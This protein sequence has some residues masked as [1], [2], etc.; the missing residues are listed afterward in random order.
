MREMMRGLAGKAH[1]GAMQNV[2]TDAGD[3]IIGGADGSPVRVGK[4]SDDHIMKMV[5]GVP[6]WTTSTHASSHAAGQ[7]D[8]ISPSDIGAMVNPMTAEGDILVGG[9]SGAPSKLA[10]GNNGQVVS[11]V[12][13]VPA[14]ATIS[15]T[16]IGG[17][18]TI[19]SPTTFYIS[20]S[21]N[22]S[23]GDGS[24]GSPWA[25]LGKALTYLNGYALLADVTIQITDGTY[26]IA[27]SG[28]N[29][30]HNNSDRIFIRGNFSAPAN[31][32]LNFTTPNAVGFKIDGL[33]KLNLGGV[34]LTGPGTTGGSY[35]IH[36]IN[37]GT[38]Y[39]D[40]SVLNGVLINN[41]NAGIYGMYGACIY[42]AA[43]VNITTCYYGIMLDAG[44]TAVTPS[45][46]VNLTGVSGAR[47]AQIGIN[48]TLYCGGVSLTGGALGA[49]AW[50]GGYIYM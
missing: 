12:A 37:N 46:A 21:G 14:W 45:S 19:T 28:Y 36:M 5:S 18:P 22:D 48:C 47:C 2:M 30:T 6:A 15:V 1:L 13:G 3:M 31:V 35:A 10:K 9:S 42:A 41:W 25:S 40:G 49:F 20:T 29:I 33:H 34:R 39:L 23:T 50:G 27:G 43:G 32:V 16:N 38:A 26:T 4:G 7:S 8:S 17:L 11:M 24:S 44:S